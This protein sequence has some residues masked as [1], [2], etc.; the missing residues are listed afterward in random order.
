[1]HI[2]K[3]VDEGS[4]SHRNI[5]RGNLSSRR[6]LATAPS[7]L[8]PPLW[9]CETDPLPPAAIHV[10]VATFNAAPEQLLPW[11]W[12]LGLTNAAVFVYYRTDDPVV[13]AMYD[14][15][16]QLPCNM[17]LTVLPLLPN[18]GREAAV[19]LHHIVTH[20]NQLPLVRPYEC[21]A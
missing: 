6:N 20:F 17:S 18:K 5:F 11:L 4:H 19:F 21:T 13:P 10:I 2:L 15:T 14:G 8:F 9:G 12:H 16:V 1:M 3:D 7:E